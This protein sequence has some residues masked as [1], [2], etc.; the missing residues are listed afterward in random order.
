MAPAPSPQTRSPPAKRPAGDEFYLR[1]PK[2]AHENNCP[3]GLLKARS[4]RARA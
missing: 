4:R 2:A 1:R 3:Q